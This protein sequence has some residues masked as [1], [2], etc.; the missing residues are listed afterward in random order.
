MAKALVIIAA[1]LLLA[2]CSTTGSLCT[3]GPIIPDAG[4][5]TR[6]TEN[7]QDQVIVLNESGEE[8]C[9]WRAP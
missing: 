7:E 2:G 4:A 3:A 5:S 6:W 9:G 1:C 8:I